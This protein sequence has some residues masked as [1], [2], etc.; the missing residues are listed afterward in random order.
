MFAAT[1]V[2]GGL[3]TRV[4]RLL[5]F[6]AVALT[7]LGTGLGVALAPEQADARHVEQIEEPIES[8]PNGSRRSRAW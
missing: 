6:G 2:G 1:T 8:N 5:A 4:G 7:T 3:R